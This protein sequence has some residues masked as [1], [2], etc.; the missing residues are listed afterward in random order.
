[1]Y[2]CTS[3]LERSLIFPAL[4]ETSTP[5]THVHVFYG[6]HPDVTNEEYGWGPFPF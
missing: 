3:L 4:F 6:M 1:M 2:I 5:Q